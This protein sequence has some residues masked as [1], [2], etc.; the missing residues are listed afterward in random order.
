MIPELKIVKVEEQGVWTG[1]V[2]TDWNDPLNWGMSFLPDDTTAVIV[3]TC[4]AGGR[5]PHVVNSDRVCGSLTVEPAGSLFVDLGGSNRLIA[6]GDVVNNGTIT[7]GGNTAGDLVIDGA[8]APRVLSG[9]GAWVGG[10]LVVD[11]GSCSLAN[12]VTL[13]SI[14]TDS[15]PGE[16]NFN[17]G[18]HT[19][20][21]EGDVV[22]DGD[23]VCPGTINVGG[24]WTFDTTAGNL[25]ASGGLVRFNGSGSAVIQHPSIVDFD[26]LAIEKSGGGEVSLQADFTADDLT[27]AEGT[28]SLSTGVS[29]VSGAF[30]IE[31]GGTLLMSNGP[32]EL[33]AYFV[34]VEAGGTLTINTGFLYL[35]ES[36]GVAGDF[37]LS[38]F[39]V[40]EPV[41]LTPVEGY[42]T[43]VSGSGGTMSG[44]EL[45]VFGGA[46][47][48][49]GTTWTA[50]GGLI[51]ARA[52]E[53]WVVVSFKMHDSSV[54]LPDVVVEADVEAEIHSATTEVLDVGGSM[55]LEAGAM[56][57]LNGKSMAVG[58]FL[59][60]TDANLR[61]PGT[62]DG[63]VTNYGNIE[64][65]TSPRVLH[66]TGDFTH[67][68]DTDI[69][70]NIGGADASQHDWL[71]IGG[72]ANLNGFLEA[73][74]TGGFTP[75]IGDSFVVARFGSR[76]GQFALFTVSHAPPPGAVWSMGYSDTTAVLI[77]ED[78]GWQPAMVAVS[79]VPGDQGGWVRVRFARSV[80][81]APGETVYPIATYDLHRRIDDGGLAQ[82]VVT[83]GERLPVGANLPHA[84]RERI[85][86]KI[87]L[88][89]SSARRYRYDDR[90]FTVTAGEVPLAPPPG[91]WEV[92]ASVIPYS[93]FYVSAH[94]TTPSAY[95]DSPADSGYSV[96]NIAPGVPSGFAVAYNTGS[97]NQLSWDPS[98]DDDFQYFRVYRS[99]DENFTPTLQDLVHSTVQA[100]WADPEYDGGGMH[101]KVT[102]LDYVGNESPP[103]TPET[104]SG[105]G[106]QNPIARYALYR[107]VPNPFNPTTV[108]NYDVPEGG[109]MVTLRI[110]D[111]SGRLCRTLANGVVSAGEKSVTWNGRDDH[112]RHVTSGVYFYRMTAPGFTKTRK[113]VLL[114]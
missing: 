51:R 41:S 91:T 15:A 103:A 107:N 24:D 42:I 73:T 114:K 105:M 87:G 97:G 56:W 16:G 11:N 99:T 27:V 19:L 29:E 72:L 14:K 52:L 32:I 61:G 60:G 102:A 80:K 106:G 74:L 39:G 13:N 64:L 100:S 110:Y 76:S 66:I 112:G 12:D 59:T 6:H 93:V 57:R 7:M 4:P 36:L 82:A 5:W 17:V 81:D 94:T 21:V 67:G 31:D 50:T 48:L 70:V 22:N 92:V 71:N 75:A 77:A 20:T 69:R 45:V 33:T 111:V 8:G 79:D 83:N 37:N 28:F 96:D 101:Y 89:P 53:P 104:V 44:G 1:N 55:T 35:F 54:Q 40:V 38:G 78:L 113:M 2:S 34:A 46:S 68:P 3:P 9:S 95:F 30:V 86:S 23:I 84:D 26:A 18:A 98:D 108:I 109:G 88:V 49:D 43:F 62:I 63:T 25:S 90:V 47:W 58:A 10:Q 85:A 65:E